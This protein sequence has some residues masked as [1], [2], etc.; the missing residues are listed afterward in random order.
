MSPPAQ[1]TVKKVITRDSMFAKVTKKGLTV[2]KRI[3]ILNTIFENHLFTYDF[4]KYFNY[5]YDAIQMLLTGSQMQKGDFEKIFTYQKTMEKEF[6]ELDDDYKGRDK[7]CKKCLLT[8][9]KLSLEDF[10]KRVPLLDCLLEER[11]EKQLIVPAFQVFVFLWIVIVVLMTYTLY[12]NE[13]EKE[14]N[15]QVALYVANCFKSSNDCF[16]EIVTKA[17]EYDKL[18]TNNSGITPNQIDWF[19]VPID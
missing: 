16:A 18:V 12:R 6:N 1:T 11:K 19:E 15:D 17:M 13:M 2:S 4:G 3:E 14:K 8:A 5:W 10:V 7:F 9:F